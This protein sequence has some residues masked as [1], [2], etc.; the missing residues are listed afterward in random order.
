M[1]QIRTL[2]RL[3]P[4]VATR[5]AA[6][7]LAVLFCAVFPLV[8][9]S[10]GYF[11]AL[12][13]FAKLVPLVVFVIGCVLAPFYGF[14]TWSVITTDEGITAVSLFK[15]PYCKW[16][17]LE[18]LKRRT[19]FNQVRY[20]VSTKSGQELNFPIWLTECDR[21]IHEIR[22][23]IPGG[24]EA[25]EVSSTQSFR[26]SLT[27]MIF[28]LVQSCLGLFFTCFVWYFLLTSLMLKPGSV[29][30]RA[31]VGIFAALLTGI[32]CWR[33]FVVILMPTYVE[34]SPETLLLKTFFTTVQ[35]NWD[36]VLRVTQPS[37]FLPE[38]FLL[39]TKRGNFLMSGTL[40]DCDELKAQIDGVLAERSPAPTTTPGKL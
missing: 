38:G 11:N 12:P 16:Q 20:S 5:I 9:Y 13:W 26:N 35:M 2:Y 19:L 31:L 8:G 7:A 18:S 17:D 37:P 33:A 10:C 22:S 30:D 36:D 29:A 3:K 15:R 21:L 14:I 40:E 27:G 1:Q 6:E 4:V 32:F 24:L 34:T 23:H 28:Q 39:K 25:L